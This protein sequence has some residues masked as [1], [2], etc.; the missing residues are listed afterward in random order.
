MKQMTENGF[1]QLQL[2]QI[3]RKSDPAGQH[4]GDYLNLFPTGSAFRLQ[5]RIKKR[6]RPDRQGAG[7]SG[8]L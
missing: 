7:G 4:N 6:I 1:I 5:K 3:D 2:V 8:T